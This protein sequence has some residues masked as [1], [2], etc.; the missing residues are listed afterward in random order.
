M[1]DYDHICKYIDIEN[2]KIFCQ[3]VTHCDTCN[4]GEDCY[5][6][7]EGRS[8]KYKKEKYKKEKYDVYKK[9]MRETCGYE[10]IEPI[11]QA[12]WMDKVL[13]NQEKIIKWLEEEI[14]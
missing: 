1:G 4:G 12:L 11:K 10:N 9:Y 14:G 6:L 7:E 2:G 13:K 8:E 3:Y 5:V